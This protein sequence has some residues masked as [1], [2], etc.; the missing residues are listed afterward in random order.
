LSVQNEQ[1]GQP[2]F[3]SAEHEMLNDELALAI[4]QVGRR[5]LA[6]RRFEA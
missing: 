2:S 1:L 3:Q 6:F 5:H 4:E